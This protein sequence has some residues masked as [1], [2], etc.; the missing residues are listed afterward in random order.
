MIHVP[1]YRTERSP[2]ITTMNTVGVVHL[3]DNK[4]GDLGR[5]TNWQTFMYFGQLAQVSVYMQCAC[6]C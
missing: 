4:L 1:I 6:V 2:V 3:A 5:N